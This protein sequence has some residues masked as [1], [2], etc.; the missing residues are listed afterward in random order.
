M[1]KSAGLRH[2]DPST[3][4]CAPPV[5]S[6][7]GGLRT[8]YEEVYTLLCVYEIY[9][10]MHMGGITGRERCVCCLVR[11][12]YGDPAGNLVLLFTGRTKKTTTT[13]KREREKK[14]HASHEEEQKPPSPPPTTVGHTHVAFRSREP[15]EEAH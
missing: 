2:E 14:N 3:F 6:P 5:S 15:R 10:R 12:L 8:I 7:R 11:S 13:T 9:I 4:A 1:A